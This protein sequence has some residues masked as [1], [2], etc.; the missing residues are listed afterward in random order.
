MT[1]LEYFRAAYEGC[2]NDPHNLAE[3][4]TLKHLQV[5]C[6][7]DCGEATTAWL[8]K[9]GVNGQDMRNAEDAGLIAYATNIGPLKMGGYRLTAKGIKTLYQQMTG[10]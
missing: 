10:K 1:A 9:A 2:K 3:P 7:Y 5:A 4:G 8:Y 6:K